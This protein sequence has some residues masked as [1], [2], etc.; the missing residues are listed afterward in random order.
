M[1]AAAGSQGGYGH[2][3]AGGLGRLASL[4]AFLAPGATSAQ[5]WLP[6][7]NTFSS[8]VVF[9]DTLNREHYTADSTTVDV[10]HTRA[11]SLGFVV[12]Y[13]PTDRL[14]LTA[15]IP[16]V[17]TRFWGPP[18]HGG[19]PHAVDDDGDEHTTFTD[20]RFGAH[21]QLLEEPVALAPLVAIVIPSHDYGTFGHAAHGRGLNEYWIG[22]SIGKNLS[23]WIP[24]TYTQL[25][26]TYAFVEKVQ[27]IGHNRSNYYYELGKF[28]TRRFNV[29]AFAAWQQT[30]G[31]IDA[32]VP[33]S[34]P[35]YLNHDK[36]QDEEFVNLGFGGGYS[37]T[38]EL[39]AFA[40]YMT[41]IDG[42]NT[43]KLNQGLT[44][45]LTYG[46]RP[47]AESGAADD[48]PGE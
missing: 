6:E 18:S 17:T 32:P 14:M 25:R 36:I 33:R 19:D 5:A 20:F 11:Q 15:G 45:G 13:S 24:G 29:S 27:D 30:H 48:L 22:L 2:F 43:H 7:A 34:S 3:V 1:H 4:I 42:Q 31:G 35:Y 26:Y 8:V 39:T 47:R 23:E 37:L 10:G 9:N 41:S 21:Y 46:Y 44:I 16:L 12:T 40:T 38:P 28:F